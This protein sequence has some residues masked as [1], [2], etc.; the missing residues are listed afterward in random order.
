MRLIRHS[1]FA[2]SS[3]LTTKGLWAK[4]I[5]F[6]SPP[7]S[8]SPFQ[9]LRLVGHLG[10][11]VDDDP[12]RELLRSNPS[13]LGLHFAGHGFTKEEIGFIVNSGRERNVTKILS[14]AFPSS[15][16]VTSRRKAQDSCGETHATCR[17]FPTIRQQGLCESPI[18]PSEFHQHGCFQMVHRWKKCLRRHRYEVS[19]TRVS[20]NRRGSAR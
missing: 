5:A 3:S 12:P 8:P 19:P 15:H 4:S 11:V 7:P 14:W 1:P 18:L 17:T 20:P 16:Y 10:A 13:D 2:R 6:R 9:N